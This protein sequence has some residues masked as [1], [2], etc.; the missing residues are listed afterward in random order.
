MKGRTHKIS[1]IFVARDAFRPSCI[2]F[3]YRF[4]HEKLTSGDGTFINAIFNSVESSE[5]CMDSL[6]IRLRLQCLQCL[7]FT[8]DVQGHVVYHISRSKSKLL[9]LSQKKLLPS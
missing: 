9:G 5:W 7:V 6:I 2:S 8:Q 3:Y 1:K 4:V